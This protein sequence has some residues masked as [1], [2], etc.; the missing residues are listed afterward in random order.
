LCGGKVEREREDWM[1]ERKVGKVGREGRE[2]KRRER[3][4][5]EECGAVRCETKRKQKQKQRQKQT[6]TGDGDGGWMHRLAGCLLT[7]SLPD[8]GQV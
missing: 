4:E 6:R 2:E 1:E 7:F 8:C 3:R 5:S